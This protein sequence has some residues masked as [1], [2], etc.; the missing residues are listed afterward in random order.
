MNPMIFGDAPT[1]PP[2]LMDEYSDSGNSLTLHLSPPTS[3]MFYFLQAGDHLS[4]PPVLQ[5][6]GQH[7]CFQRNVPTTSGWTDIKF[8]TDT[9][10]PRE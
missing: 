4:F 7:F 5:G 9:M 2:V 1:L 10:V 8:G 3:Q 6:S